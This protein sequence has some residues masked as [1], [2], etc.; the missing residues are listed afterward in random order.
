M[1]RTL[2]TDVINSNEEKL[3]LTQFEDHPL[4]TFLFI[5][6]P[7]VSAWSHFYSLNLSVHNC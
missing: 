7:F 4:T 1:G 2:K 6:F 5:K 3:Q